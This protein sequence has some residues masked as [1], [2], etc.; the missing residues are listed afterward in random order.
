MTEKTKENILKFNIESHL[1]QSGRGYHLWIFFEKPIL[2][3][4][5]EDFQ[6]QLE[7]S[8]TPFNVMNVCIK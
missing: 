3:S 2:R 6:A 5:V 7:A 4:R 1:E 8:G